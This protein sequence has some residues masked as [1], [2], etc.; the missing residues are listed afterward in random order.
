VCDKEDMAKTPNGWKKFYRDLRDEL[1][2]YFYNKEKKD[3]VLFPK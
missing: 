3:F 2:S 1:N